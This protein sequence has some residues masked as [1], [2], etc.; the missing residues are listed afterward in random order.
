MSICASSVYR[1]SVCLHYGGV[2]REVIILVV[3]RTV[4]VPRCLESYFRTNITWL[5]VSELCEH[6][7]FPF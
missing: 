4:C 3:V 1:I 2:P 5:R 6:S 7:D